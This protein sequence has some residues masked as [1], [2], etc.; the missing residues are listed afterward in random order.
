MLGYDERAESITGEYVPSKIWLEVP[1]KW[2]F[3]G[4]Y[5]AFLPDS[6][7]FVCYRYT[8]G[9]MGVSLAGG[10]QLMGLRGRKMCGE[11]KSD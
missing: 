4:E 1:W 9:G 7:S 3:Y 2:Y 8:R 5:D 6:L 11:L 10:G